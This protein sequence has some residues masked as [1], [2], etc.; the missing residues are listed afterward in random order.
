MTDMFGEIHDHNALERFVLLGHLIA[1][2]GMQACA[3]LLLGSQPPTMR[4]L[5]THTTNTFFFPCHV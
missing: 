5:M 2:F 4:M 3:G 1:L